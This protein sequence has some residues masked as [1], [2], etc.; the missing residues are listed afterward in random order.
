MP[1]WYLLKT[2][3]AKDAVFSQASAGEENTNGVRVVARLGANPLL[4]HRH[5]ATV[6]RRNKKAGINKPSPRYE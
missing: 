5:P 6:E 3:I 2:E 1:R 4:H